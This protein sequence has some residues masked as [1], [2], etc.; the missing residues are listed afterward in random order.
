MTDDNDDLGPIERLN[1]LRRSGVITAEEFTEFKASILPRDLPISPTAPSPKQGSRGSG[2]WLMT[3]AALAIVA[4]GSAFVSSRYAGLD[5][6]SLAAS[7]SGEP[8]IGRPALAVPSASS[9]PPP[10][11]VTR[12]PSASS[13]MPDPGKA[14]GNQVVLQSQNQTSSRTAATDASP[15]S[16][17]KVEYSPAYNQCMATGDAARGTTMGILDCIAPEND[18]QD[19]RLNRAYK[20]SMQQ[21]SSSAQATL[22]KSERFWLREREATCT[23]DGS[24]FEGGTL[25]R[26]AYAQCLVN[27]T[28]KRATW[29][30]SMG[31]DASGALWRP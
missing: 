29:L 6:R 26:V 3:V 13:A 17:D 27:E 22:R 14:L 19:L 30:E 8:S 4:A 28:I 9:Q 10:A 18:R 20:L 12:A 25:Q 16:D 31:G 2:I 24:P 11:E 23:A 1:A 21:S 15:Q 5:L 7:S